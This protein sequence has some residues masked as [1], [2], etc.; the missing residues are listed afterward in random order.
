MSIFSKAGD[1]TFFFRRVFP[2]RKM[3]VSAYPSEIGGTFV[4]K[5]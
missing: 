4:D 3:L 2:V 5:I 1:F